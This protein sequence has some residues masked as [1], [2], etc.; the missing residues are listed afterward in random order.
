MV[1]ATH[2]PMPTVMGMPMNMCMGTYTIGKHASRV[3]RFG[4]NY[5]DWPAWVK[6][7]VNTHFDLV[8]GPFWA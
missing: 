4:P 2:M 6:F 8:S 5:P 3:D 7:M 1:I